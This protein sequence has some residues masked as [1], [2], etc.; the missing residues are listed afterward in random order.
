MRRGAFFFSGQEERCARN[1]DAAAVRGT[2]ACVRDA[3]PAPS[4]TAG[5]CRE[6]PHF[7]S[8]PQLS[9]KP[10]APCAAVTP[11][12]ASRNAGFNFPFALAVANVPL[13]RQRGGAKRSRGRGAEQPG[14]QPRAP[15]GVALPRPA[16]PGG[17]G[18][19]RCGAPARRGAPESAVPA[20]RPSSAACE[21]RS[22]RGSCAPQPQSG[23]LR[24][25]SCRGGEARLSFVFTFCARTESAV[26]PE[27][28][29]PA[30]TMVA[31]DYPFYLSVKRANCALEVQTVTSPAKE[32][33]VPSLLVIRLHLCF[34]L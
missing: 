10:N 24:L 22:S 26:T 15:G 28:A 1:V 11:C 25:Q 34:S 3:T 21:R 16:A 8:A 23:D 32:T 5:S 6:A 29:P 30:A 9:E 14:R 33:E 4:G 13:R 27:A 31:K 20:G 7:S 19:Q 17:G 12:E 18:E 2:A